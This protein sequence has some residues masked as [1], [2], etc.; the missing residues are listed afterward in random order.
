MV[1]GI[2]K[3]FCDSSLLIDL[4]LGYESTFN[5]FL[6][7][8]DRVFIADTVK[9]ELKNLLKKLEAYEHLYIDLFLPNQKIDIIYAKDFSS[10]ELTVIEA[11]LK[12]FDMGVSLINQEICP[13]LGEFVSALY[14]K[15]KDI[16]V[17]RTSDKKFISRYGNNYIFKNIKFINLES[18]LDE[19]LDNKDKEETLIKIRSGN[20]NFNEHKNEYRLNKSKEDLMRRFQK[21]KLS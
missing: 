10:E 1:S 20:E 16:N 5:K 15:Y 8:Q 18:T 11:T 7:S 9:Y 17:V 21:H 4:K 6:E 14:S 2:K 13:D 19:F 3:S 12:Q